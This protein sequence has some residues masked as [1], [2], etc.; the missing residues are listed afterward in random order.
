M[1]H[2]KRTLNLF[3][4]TVAGVGIILGAGI[5]AL[6]GAA[7]GIAGNG[8]WLSFTIAAIISIFTGLSYA[9]LSTLFKDDGGEYDYV[10]NAFN[11]NIAWIIGM[12]VI[13]TG[14][15]SAATVAL[16]FGGYL[17]AIVGIDEKILFAFIIIVLSS[18]INIIGIKQTSILNIIC[19]SIEFLGLAIIIIFGIKNIGTI[20][21]LPSFENIHNIFSGAALV[22]FAYMGFESIVKLSE[23]TKNPEKTLPRALVLSIII[24][25]ILY[26]TVALVAI[27]TIPWEAL[28]ASKAPLATVAAALLGNNVFLLIGVI[29]LFSTANTVLITIATTSRMIYGMAQKKSL[30]AWLASINPLTNT[31]VKAIIAFTLFIILLSLIGNIE[32]VAYLNDSFLFLTFAMVNLSVIILRYKQPTPRKFRMPLNIGKFPV[33]ALLGVIV[34]LWMLCYAIAGLF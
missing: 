19:T 30:P 24:S 5:Y 6:I 17:S 14:F 27:S 9:E 21:Y 4:V 31:P 18:V 33:L 34:S 11:K 22:F 23:E 25:S 26:I 7:A 8:V 20:S 3:D 13:A 10:K 16:G 29:A 28:A 15:I 2:L 32:F 1:V 12:F